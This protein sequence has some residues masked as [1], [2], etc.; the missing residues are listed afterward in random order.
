VIVLK[1]PNESVS[2]VVVDSTGKA[3]ANCPVGGRGAGQPQRRTETDAQGRF[4]LREI[5]PGPIEIWAKL[6]SVLYGTVEAEAG[7][8]NVRLVASPIP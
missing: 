8:K 2:G 3:V 5:C 7:Q 1:R 4:T 6:D